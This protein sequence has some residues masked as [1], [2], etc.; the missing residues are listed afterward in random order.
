M[1]TSPPVLDSKQR[2]WYRQQDDMLQEEDAEELTADEAVDAD[3]SVTDNEYTTVNLLLH[4]LHM[5]RCPHA[6]DRVTAS[7]YH[8]ES[9]MH[10]AS[11][12]SYDSIGLS[13]RT[14]SSLVEPAVDAPSAFLAKGHFVLRSGDEFE[15]LETL[16]VKSWYENRNRL[17]GALVLDRR[18][19][20]HSDNHVR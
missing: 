17:L 4:D 5:H 8:H 15:D 10:D 18:R 19:N 20:H 13:S 9:A 3:Y 7:P 16:N 2:G 11:T 12:A 14:S 6:P 1:R